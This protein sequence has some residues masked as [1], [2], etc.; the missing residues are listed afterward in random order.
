[1]R[2][3]KILFPDRTKWY[4]M[5][6]QKILFPDSTKWYLMEATKYTLQYLKF[7]CILTIRH[8]CN[9]IRTVTEAPNYLLPTSI[10]S[11]PVELNKIREIPYQEWGETGS[12]GFSYFLLFVHRW[13]FSTLREVWFWLQDWPPLLW[14]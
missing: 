7:N 11:C 3:Q 13:A 9:T 4:L 5:R 10:L 12:C 2:Q 8:G 1:M 6:Q 14:S